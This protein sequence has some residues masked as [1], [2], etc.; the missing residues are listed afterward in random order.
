MTS[1]TLLVSTQSHHL[2]ELSD[3]ADNHCKLAGFFYF[4]RRAL[5][6]SDALEQQITPLDLV[7][8][9]GYIL[10]LIHI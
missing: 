3:T 1:E 8:P 4:S 10:S 6:A 5:Q 9:K 7:V 2:V